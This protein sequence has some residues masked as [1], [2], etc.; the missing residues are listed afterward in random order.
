MRV[1]VTGAS[2]L[3]GSALVPHLR[4]TG[5]DVVRFVRGTAKAR[6]ER[7]WDPS[8]RRLD[9]ALLEDV[10]AVVHLAGA[11]VADKRWT[12]SYKDKILRSRV[13]GT[14]A[15]A[16]AIAA[17]GHPTVLLSASAV[18]WYGD[19]GD[20][21][22]DE[23]G[24]TGEGFLAEVCREWE[25]ATQPAEGTARVSH[26]RTGYVLAEDALGLRKQVQVARLGLGAPLGSGRQWMSWITLSDE[27]RAI[28]HLLTAAVAGPVNLVGPN[29]ATNAELTRAINRAVHRPT[30]PVP[31]PGFA[32]K[33]ALGPFASEGVLIGQRLAPA[34]LART[35]FTFVHSELDAALA[36]MLTPA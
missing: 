25:D 10:D 7:T 14:T 17:S 19:T 13:D 22:T 32:L 33:A 18:G 8:A 5:H 6:D 1:A 15:V 11:G 27:V 3:I 24:P 28:T 23:T 34:V 12:P 30:F 29:P 9:P 4:E 16:E 36:A 26:L 21:L 20:R 35:G 2:G 31:V